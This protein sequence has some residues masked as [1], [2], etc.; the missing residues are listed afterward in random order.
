MASFAGVLLVIRPGSLAFHPAT[1]LSVSN[2]VLYAAFNLLTRRMAATES[3]EA[4][5]LL[6]AAGAAL[7]LARPAL[8]Q[9]Q[10]PTGALSW[11]LIALCGL[12]GGLDHLDGMA[13]GL[14]R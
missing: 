12:M 2:A 6:S 5:Q 7:V 8:L 10:A 3:P 14:N 9:W 4:M 11:G 13:A 1:L